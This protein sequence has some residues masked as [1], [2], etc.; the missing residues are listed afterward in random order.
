M[1]W[2]LAL[3]LMFVYC[4]PAFPEAVIRQTDVLLG[5]PPRKSLV[6]NS[7]AQ[8][9]ER[10]FFDQRLSASGAISCGSCHVASQSFTDGRSK[11]IGHLG[12]PGT[13]NA[14]SLLNVA[15]MKPLFWDGRAAD[16]MHQARAPFVNPVEHALPD[17]DA[18]D[19]IVSA[20]PV[21]AAEFARLWPD[22]GDNIQM[23]MISAALSA[24]EQTLLSG[25]SPFDRYYY[26]NDKR[27]LNAAAVRGFELFRG[28]AN[29]NSCHAIGERWSLF[30]DQAFHAATR[31][32]P[33]AVSAD[34]LSLAQRV[35][36]AKGAGNPLALEL[37]LATDAQVAALGR[38]VVTLD[39][40]DIGK[41]KTPSLRNVALTTPYMHDG[42]VATLREAIELELYQ[43]GA[44]AHPIILT[45][46]EKS[47]LLEFLN[48]LSGAHATR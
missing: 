18:L 7:I 16:L 45:R 4:A 25:G 19:R 44:V 35:V 32:L 48:S 5:L 29:C 3:Y 34:L 23:E 17:E 24:F 28:R 14:P 20:D 38:F 8:L 33:S 10:L 31:G 42:S 13:R 2:R 39:P 6:D 11:S 46:D 12:K 40:A 41:F 36:T 26:A 22:A 47:D 1:H 9:G 30:T 21:Y 15:Y 37:L 43:R 27:A